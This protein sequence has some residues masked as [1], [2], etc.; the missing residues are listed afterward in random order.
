[1]SDKASIFEKVLF[2][3]RIPILI[4][5]TFVTVF[6]G[7]NAMQIS[8]DTSMR[9]MV[10]LNHEYIQNLLKHK[11]ELSLG[12]DLRIAVEV[13]EG[14]IFTKEFLQVLKDVTDEVFYLQ[15]VDKSKIKS[16]WT[17]NVRW[18]EV[19]EEGFI[20]GEVIPATYDGSDE[21]IE[22]LQQNVLKSG[23]VG[24]LVSDDFKSAIVYVPLLD[25]DESKGEKL[26][27]SRLS[28]DLEE[29]VRDRFQDDKIK[30]HIIG[31]AKKVGDLIDGAQGVAVF[32][33]ITIAITT[34]LL[35][36]DTRCW[37]SSV[38]VVV[39]SI[40]AV[41]WQ[42]GIVSLLHGWVESLKASG[43]W[44]AFV[45][46]FPSFE[47]I[48]FGI[49]PYSMLVP[50]L[51]FAIAV[52]HGVQIINE[53]T[54]RSA[55]GDDNFT[56]ASGAFRA[57]YI[58]GILALASDAIGF[59]TLWFIDIGVIRELAITAS[60]GV[61]TIILTKLVFVPIVLSFI[62]VEKAGVESVRRKQKNPPKI[63]KYL[64]NFADPKVAVI[65]IVVAVILAGVGINIKQDLKIGDLDPGA[66]E[67]RPDSRYNLDDRFIVANYSVSADVLVVLVETP[68]ESCSNYGAMNA[69]DRFMWHM[70]NVP[71]VQSSLS[72]VTASKLV[73]TGNNEGSLKWRE[74]SKI[75]DILN[76]SMGQLPSGLMNLN[77]SLAP[78]FLFLDDHKAETL[79]RV[80]TAVSDFAVINDDPEVARFVLASGNAGV[81]AAT[82]QTIAKAE[83]TMLTLVYLVVCTMVFITFRS[84]RPVVCIVLPL[85]LTSILCEA[86]MTIMGIGVKVATL[87]VIALGVGIGVDYGIYIYAKMNFHMQR[88]L[89]VKDAYFETL[90]VTG[91][92]VVF[93]GITLGFGV[94]T[95]IFSDIKFQADMGIL[96]TFMF[97]WNMIGAI[98]LLPALAEFLVGKK[99][100]RDNLI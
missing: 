84:W 28:K 6:L 98:W 24:R 31:F 82:N 43:A 80:V 19:T 35:L 74:I 99:H 18:V 100:R 16:L 60:V 62:G 58:P 78:V 46:R 90:R 40:F 7:F 44:P 29:K 71:G 53:M 36:F 88:G 50:F 33:L 55:N 61:A 10:P 59:I 8:M 92:S 38:T 11:D 83:V 26:D 70:E 63:W 91:K 9:K 81:E 17:P 4:I 68:D 65:S 64:A 27:Y 30:I 75:Q 93:T 22:T 20:G 34:M 95:W 94:G 72:L 96:L 42:L 12:N 57:L 47:A 86:L 69:I 45:E 79:E 37:K 97:V 32:F 52:S 67:L 48:Q 25:L 66:P 89:D 41:V 56:A 1:M 76:S 5:F 15:G 49:D 13:T 85:L 2:S 23:Q 39:G 14:D 21:A 77:C 51:V 87:P 3:Y 73:T 54:V